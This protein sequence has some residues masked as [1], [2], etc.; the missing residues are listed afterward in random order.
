MNYHASDLNC[1]SFDKNVNK[2]ESLTFVKVS[3]LEKIVKCESCS[4][5]KHLKIS[6]YEKASSIQAGKVRI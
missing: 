4:N 1:L 2:S 3:K 5:V 6:D